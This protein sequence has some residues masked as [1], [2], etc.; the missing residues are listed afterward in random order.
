MIPV[1]CL[2]RDGSG[3]YVYRIES[4][5]RVKTPV[6]AGV[7]NEL[8]VEITEGLTEGDEVYVRN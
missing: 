6:A 1:T 3:Y 8:M 4:G 7:R 5:S 2:Y